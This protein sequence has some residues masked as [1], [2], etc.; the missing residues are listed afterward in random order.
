MPTRRPRNSRTTSTFADLNDAHA[1]VSSLW[2]GLPCCA[3]KQT[4]AIYST[5]QAVDEP[6]ELLLGYVGPAEVQRD[7]LPTD[8]PAEHEWRDG[9]AA[10]QVDA[11]PQS[12][13]AT[14]AE[15][16][17]DKVQTFGCCTLAHFSGSSTLFE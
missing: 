5:W 15:A 7:G 8:D 3:A 10:V 14:P 17:I 11:C 9:G 4:S 6:A 16:G 13:V 12:L 2:A 1:D